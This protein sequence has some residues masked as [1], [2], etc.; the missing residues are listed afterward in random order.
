MKSL[1]INGLRLGGAVASMCAGLA[2]MFIA[3]AGAPAVFVSAAALLISLLCAMC[4]DKLLTEKVRDETRAE[5]REIVRPRVLDHPPRPL[6]TALPADLM[7][8]HEE[9]ARVAMQAGEFAADVIARSRLMIERLGHV[10]AHLAAVET[11]REH[12]SER[13]ALLDH[14]ATQITT[15]PR[16]QFSLDDHA[17]IPQFMQSGPAPSDDELIA[18]VENAIIP[19]GAA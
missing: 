1:A 9:L 10:D 15:A 3:E 13:A 18:G 4:G 11:D 2:L 6:H 14:I 8:E 12:L 7:A 17:P 16:P 19:K 5:R